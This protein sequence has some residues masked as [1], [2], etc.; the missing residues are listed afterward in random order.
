MLN[1]QPTTNSRVGKVYKSQNCA[2]VNGMRVCDPVEIIGSP[3]EECKKC[4][5]HE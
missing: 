2:R 1:E 5:D 4:G 3:I